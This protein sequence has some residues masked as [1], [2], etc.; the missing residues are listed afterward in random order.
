MRIVTRRRLGRHPVRHG[1]N[2]L[3]AA[4]LIAGCR[5]L[6]YAADPCLSHEPAEVQLRGR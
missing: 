1:L 6:A 5:S 2:G 3:L 4:V